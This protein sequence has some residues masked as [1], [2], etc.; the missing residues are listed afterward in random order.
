MTKPRINPGETVVRRK[1]RHLVLVTGGG[2]GLVADSPPERTV[3]P[4]EHADQSSCK[5]VRLIAARDGRPIDWAE[6]VE[7]VWSG[8]DPDAYEIRLSSVSPSRT[9]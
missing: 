9:D 5:Q 4:M 2:E 6:A 8:A 3:R 1:V 7:A